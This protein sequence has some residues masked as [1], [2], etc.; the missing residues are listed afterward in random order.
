MLLLFS[1]A[2]FIIPCGQCYGPMIHSSLALL[3]SILSRRKNTGA[4]A[5]CIPCCEPQ[6]STI[7]E[8]VIHAIRNVAGL[9]RETHKPYPSR[10]EYIMIDNVAKLS[11]RAK[12]CYPFLVCTTRPKSYKVAPFAG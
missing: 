11:R 7:L 2:T 8:Q 6:F 12:A 1:F 10:G 9:A 4:N 5:L 3:L